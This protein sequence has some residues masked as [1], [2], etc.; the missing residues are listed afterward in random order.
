VTPRNHLE[1]GGDEA[2]MAEGRR[3]GKVERRTV[4]LSG[5]PD[6]VVIYKHDI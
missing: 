3:A 4:D 5:Y 1:V 6:L 2:E